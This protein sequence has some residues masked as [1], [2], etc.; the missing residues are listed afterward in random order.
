MTNTSTESL[1]GIIK[2]RVHSAIEMAR[3][4]K[5]M[6]HRGTLGKLGKSS[7]ASFL[8]HIPLQQS[9]FMKCSELTLAPG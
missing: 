7:F 2:A 4:V 3:V 8:G 9:R 1:R 5:T 6:P